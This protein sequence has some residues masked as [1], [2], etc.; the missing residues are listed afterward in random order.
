VLIEGKPN[1]VTNRPH[2]LTCI[3]R[4]YQPDPSSTV[5]WF[6]KNPYQVQFRLETVNNAH[7]L[8][9][10]TMTLNPTTFTCSTLS[11]PNFHTT[12]GKHQ[13]WGTAKLP[14]PR[15][16]KSR[17]RVQRP[18]NN[19][20]QRSNTVGV[21][22]SLIPNPINRRN[23][24]SWQQLPDI[25]ALRNDRRVLE[26]QQTVYPEIMK[27]FHFPD[28]RRCLVTGWKSTFPTPVPR[29]LMME[30]RYIRR[31]VQITTKCERNF[32]VTDH[33]RFAFCYRFTRDKTRYYTLP[34]FGVL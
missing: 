33:R 15:Q 9:D 21:K 13:G 10:V 14:K 25:K 23:H 17:D 31:L 12:R 18:N 28:G 2:Q 20:F 4:F 29:D 16:E 19:V 11:V 26:I 30:N 5:L 24:F 22:S 7:W 27:P 8:R 6:H 1:G 3:A 32:K 34:Y